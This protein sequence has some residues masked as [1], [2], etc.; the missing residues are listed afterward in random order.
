MDGPHR[1][2]LGSKV[3]ETGGRT[4]PVLN[5]GESAQNPAGTSRVVVE[6]V[7]VAN[8]VRSANVHVDSPNTTVQVSTV[9]TPRTTVLGLGDGSTVTNIG[10]AAVNITFQ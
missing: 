3:C 5:K 4:M 9:G 1:A 10:P 6:I 8:Q 2:F 7:P